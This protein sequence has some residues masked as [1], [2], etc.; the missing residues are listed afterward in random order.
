MKRGDYILRYALSGQ[1]NELTSE[2]YVTSYL[3]F[4]STYGDSILIGEGKIICEYYEELA[5]DSEQVMAIIERT[6][7]VLDQTTQLVDKTSTQLVFE[8]SDR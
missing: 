8:I 1:C 4:I 7:K 3:N 5:L 2:F 6:A